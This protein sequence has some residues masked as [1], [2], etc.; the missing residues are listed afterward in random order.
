MTLRSQKASHRKSADKYHPYLLRG[1]VYC[2]N[3]CSHPPEGK[4]FSAY[5]K[6]RPQRYQKRTHHYRCRAREMGYVCDQKMV[7]AETIESQIVSILRQLKPPTGWRSGINRA[8]G[9][10]SGI[11]NL[12]TRLAG[13]GDEIRR[14]DT[15]FDKGFFIDEQEYFEQRI[16]LQQELERLQPVADDD[17][18][19]A[20]EDLC[21]FWP[22][23]QACGNDIEAQ[24][25]LVSRYVERIYVEGTVVV[26]ITLKSNYH[27]VLGHNVK[28][29]T[30]FDYQSEPS[31]PKGYDNN[32]SLKIRKPHQK[33]GYPYA[34][35]TKNLS[36]A[37]ATGVD[38]SLGTCRVT[39]VPKH[40]DIPKE[41]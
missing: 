20:V 28:K 30:E 18:E 14:M 4:N 23:F 2:Y 16:N 1:L 27:L 19:R 40:V 9:E 25:Q 7:N 36:R 31:D 38:C 33:A 22:R 6:M 34:N 12:E 3:C 11:E 32:R 41:L 17:L 13:I 26:A 15:R 29:A 24:H 39:F 21:E 35:P 8:I 5:G 10:F 37:G